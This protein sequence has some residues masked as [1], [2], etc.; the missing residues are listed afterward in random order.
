[1]LRP[2]TDDS[3][4]V[5]IV[6]QDTERSRQLRG[7]LTLAGYSVIAELAEAID[8]PQAVLG[9]KPHIII[10]SADSPDRDTLEQI[11]LTSRTAPRPVIM[12]TQDGASASIRAAVDAGVSAYVVDGLSPDRLKPILEV[13]QARFEAHQALTQKLANAEHLLTERK[14]VEKAKG[15]LMARRGMTEEQA[16][17]ELRNLAMKTG[18]RLGE[19]ADTLI[20]AAHIL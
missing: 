1:M 7:A 4:R 18:K 14:R 19:I 10:I 11:S 15:L 6:D 17:A 2:E 8:L 12:F 3:L 16:Y 9:L 5:M 13:A 20:A